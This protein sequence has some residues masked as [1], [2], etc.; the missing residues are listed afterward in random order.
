[1]INA[2]DTYLISGPRTLVVIH[3]MAID[4]AQQYHNRPE[5]QMHDQ[6]KQTNEL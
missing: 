3:A 1:M 6:S 2:H 5:H 4:A